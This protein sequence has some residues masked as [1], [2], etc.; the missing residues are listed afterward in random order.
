MARQL[1]ANR[2]EVLGRLG[3]G[4]QGEV[5]RVRDTHQGGVVALKLLSALP[6]GAHWNEA[7]VLNALR[8]DHI[9]PIRNADVASGTPYLVTDLALFGTLDDR[10]AAT[11]GCGLGV[12]QVVRW[13]RQA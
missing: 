3:G 6:G 4:A 1:I 11:G 10:L 13:I 2:Y 9:L 8:D 12:D 7:R 5:Y